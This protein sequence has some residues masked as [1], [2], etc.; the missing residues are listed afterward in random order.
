M[1][2][3]WSALD[4]AELESVLGAADPS[5]IAWLETDY[6]LEYAAED[7]D[8]TWMFYTHVLKPGL[9][10]FK[11][12]A[13]YHK[14]YFIPLV[15][16]HA[17]QQLGGIWID[18]EHMANVKE[19][20]LAKQSTYLRNILEHPTIRAGIDM[21]NNL[22]LQNMRDSKPA[23]CY[24]KVPDRKPEPKKFTQAGHVSRNWK[25]WY[26]L[27]EEIA[28]LT[29]NPEP[30]PRFTNWAAKVKVLEDA[31]ARYDELTPEEIKE[32]SLFSLTSVDDKRWLF[33]NAL[34]FPVLVYT[35]NKFNPE[36]EQK[37]SVD[38]SAMKGMGEIGELFIEWQGATKELQFVESLSSRLFGDVFHPQFKVPGTYTG[39]L[40]GAGGFSMQILPKTPS[41][42]EA[43]RPRPGH[44]LVDIDVSALE[45]V[46]LTELS[47]DE[48]L[49]SVYGPNASPHADIYLTVGARLGSVGQAFRDC[50]YDYK[51]PTK[52][53]AS[54]CKKEHKNLRGIVKKLHL[55]ASYGAGPRKIH[56]A[57]ALD[58]VSLSLDEV[59][60]M[61]GE[62]WE[63]FGSIKQYEQ[64]LVAQWE[65]NGGWF[66]N[67]LGLPAAV[68]Q[69]K[70]K[71]IINRQIQ[72]TG[73]TILTFLQKQIADDLA[74]EGIP[75]RPYVFDFHDEIILEVPDAHAKR[76][77]EIM[78][79]A[80]KKINKTLQD[81]STVVQFKGSGDVM[82]SL[83]EAKIE[84]YKSIWREGE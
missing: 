25:A 58:G 76:T 52:E 22:V 3:N 36:A 83:A 67:G 4:P 13:D 47:R 68:A 33:Y 82:Y 28:R 48:G 12:Y 71:D 55:S 72:G 49:L 84:E 40:S 57:L 77:Y 6:L 39:R 75:Y 45:P 38:E 31:I 11:A 64:R 21:F 7:T 15:E 78:D 59:R 69:D 35:Y 9:D 51:N 81:G 27:E 29:E 65:K 62:Y 10:K 18:T 80:F 43:F 42:L 63:M 26:A 44:K 34:S 70:I 16:H 19:E 66:L 5:R 56:E 50:G 37:P 23:V 30:L 2:F 24:R 74:A 17:I 79:A 73:H 1:N 53:A 46:V 41:F 54:R 8:I 61:H 14:E 60:R 32:H 20:L